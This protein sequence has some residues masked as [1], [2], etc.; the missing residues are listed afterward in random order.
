[1]GRPE[2]T[3]PGIPQGRSLAYP[4]MAGIFQ[5]S[6]RRLPKSSHCCLSSCPARVLAYQGPARAW[7]TPQEGSTW[8]TRKPGS[9]ADGVLLIRGVLLIPFR[10]YW[11]PPPRQMLDGKAAP[12]CGLYPPSLI[13]QGRVSRC[14][15]EYD[16]GSPDALGV[17]RT[18]SVLVHQQ[19]LPPDDR[20]CP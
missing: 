15:L 17:T 19:V 1:M 12:P 8:Q 4:N 2:E 18:H 3:V 9:L 7:Q 13:C 20:S 11:R 14:N 16:S 10:G 5:R 6:A